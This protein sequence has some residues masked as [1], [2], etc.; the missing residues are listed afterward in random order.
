MSKSYGHMNHNQKIDYV[1]NLKKENQHMKEVS[2]RAR[3]LSQ[4]KLIGFFVMKS[5]SIS[6]SM[7]VRPPQT[8]VVM[9]Y[10]LCL[11]VAF[12]SL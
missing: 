12:M 9:Y 7:T 1:N 3:V 8:P 10:F 2:I 5:Q 11:N 6:R 4:R